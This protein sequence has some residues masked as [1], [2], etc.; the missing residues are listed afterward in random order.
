MGPVVSKSQNV[1]DK[2]LERF[3][4]RMVAAYKKNNEIIR[5]Q[6]SRLK[7]HLGLKNY[8]QERRTGFVYYLAKFGDRFIDS[9]LDKI[10]PLDPK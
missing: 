4:R 6:I 2:K 9:V 8:P 10:N 1:L 5:K 7:T 3:E